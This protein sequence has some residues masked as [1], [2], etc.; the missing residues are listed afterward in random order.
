[1]PL[2]VSIPV[3]LFVVSVVAV[4]GAVNGV[5]GF[6]FALVGTMAL[7][8]FLDP[9]TAVVFMVLPVVAVNLSLVRELS[10]EELRSCGRRFTPLMVAAL[11]GTVVGMWF[12]ELLPDRPLRL[13]LGLVTLAFVASVQ[14]AFD[15]PG[16]ERLK[17]VCFVESTRLMVVVG[18][19]SGL[20]FGGTNVG[21]Q[22][23]AYLKSFDLSHGV[24][25]GVVAMVF[26]GLNAV[27]VAAAAALGLYPSIWVF[28]ASAAVAVPA[29]TGVAVGRR[30]RHR[31]SDRTKRA[32]VLA[33]LTAV[34]VRLVAAG[35]GVF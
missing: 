19:A 29:W 31:V 7:A 24:F 10:A 16:M 11:A 26:L 4:A 34:G 13:G 8:S 32:V 9:S 5:A 17:Q 15:V 20:L 33:L 30:F 22:L 28:G 2:S 18:V 25:V 21:V 14:R 27:R 1:M 6:G 3:A 12:L 23:V 35:L